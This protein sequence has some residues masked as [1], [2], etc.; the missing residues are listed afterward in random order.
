M[1]TNPT[2]VPKVNKLTEAQLN[3]LVGGGSI[4]KGGDTYTADESALY[5]TEEVIDSTPTQNS[6]NVIE[7]GGVYTAL[8]SKEDISNKVTSLSSSSTDTEYPSA[9]AV[10]DALSSAGGDV[11]LYAPIQN[12]DYQ[13][14]VWVPV[15]FTG[16]PSNFRG[17]HVW[18]DGIN[19]YYSDGGTNNLVLDVATKTWTTKT[20]TGFTNIEGRYIWYGVDGNIYHTDNKTTYKLDIAT[21]T[22]SSVSFYWGN[23]NFVYGDR[24]WSDGVNN[25]ICAGEYSGYW[26]GSGT[27]WTQIDWSQ[28][29]LINSRTGG[30]GIFGFGNDIYSINAGVP[31]S[32]YKFNKTNKTWTEVQITGTLGS[33]DKFYPSYILLDGRN[34][35]FTHNYSSVLSNFDITTLTVTT[36][37]T[38]P[39]NP[40]SGPATDS[41]YSF[42]IIWWSDGEN[43]YAS[44]GTEHFV[45]KPTIITKPHIS[46]K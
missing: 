16:A 31:Q 5:L 29:A 42:N 41:S 43:T 8:Q 35:Y 26:T 13:T 23:T 46:Y 24:I 18:S 17:D 10:Y 11:N 40:T 28:Y 3:M 15:T 32:F 21:S 36:D 38:I 34:V 25:Y 44:S 2:R 45:L 27:N 9:K 1:A 22:W 39:L 4:T 7:S 33:W 14:K 19:I 30:R 37:T 12:A 6:T 20:W